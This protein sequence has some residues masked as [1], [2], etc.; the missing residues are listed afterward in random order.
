MQKEVD[1][2]SSLFQ[3]SNVSRLDDA[4]TTVRS[5]SLMDATVG[6]IQG[7]MISYRTYDKNEYRDI[8]SYLLANN[9]H[10]TNEFA[11]DEAKHTLYSNGS[12]ELRLKVITT[13][14]DKRTFTAYEIELGK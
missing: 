10:K 11:F 12:R 13:I 8:S 5:L 14:K 2:A 4:P 3:Y 1:S 6:N 7:R 9:Y